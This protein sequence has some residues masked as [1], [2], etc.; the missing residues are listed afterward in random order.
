MRSNLRPLN[1]PKLVANR[2]ATS[3]EDLSAK[4]TLCGPAT[5]SSFS[6]ASD[7][8]TPTTPTFSLRGHSRYPSG[9]SSLTSS[10]TSPIFEHAEVLGSVN[11]LPM[12]KLPEEPSESDEEYG[13][14]KD[15]YDDAF[16]SCLY[17]PSSP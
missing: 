17:F 12:P 13:L 16:D 1:L 4:A 7:A 9:S 8:S 5:G 2:N 15:S 3:D 10:S 6:S 11:K 14:R